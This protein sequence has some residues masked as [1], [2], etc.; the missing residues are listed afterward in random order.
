MPSMA[1][2]AALASPGRVFTTTM[3]MAVSQL[4]TPS[5]NILARRSLCAPLTVWLGT[6]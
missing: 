6:V 1:L 4:T 3:F 5:R 2:L